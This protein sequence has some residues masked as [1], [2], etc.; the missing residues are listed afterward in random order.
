MKKE[1]KF[2]QLT[3]QEAHKSC[4]I[5]IF[6]LFDS[7]LTLPNS[8]LYGELVIEFSFSVVLQFL[9]IEWAI[10]LIRIIRCYLRNIFNKTNNDKIHVEWFIFYTFHLY[11][12]IECEVVGDACRFSL[13][14]K[15]KSNTRKYFIWVGIAR[16]NMKILFGLE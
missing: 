9:N 7:L 13:I 11:Y 6:V 16:P 3:P 5:D 12:C 2:A 10:Q 4:N 8:Q 14:N 15:I 1:V